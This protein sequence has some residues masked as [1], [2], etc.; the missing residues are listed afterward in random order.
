M[1]GGGISSLP[2]HKPLSMSPERKCQSIGVDYLAT[3]VISTKAVPFVLSGKNIF[4]YFLLR[5]ALKKPVIATVSAFKREALLR[6]AENK[7]SR[8]APQNEFQISHFSH[9]PN[10]VAIR[11][12]RM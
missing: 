9:S 6:I 12:E 5:A 2:L 8:E 7:T 4:I 10:S 1:Q 11:C 3:M